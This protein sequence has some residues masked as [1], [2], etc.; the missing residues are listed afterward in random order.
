MN[1]IRSALAAAMRSQAAPTIE[2]TQPA[3]PAD[4]PIEV[5][6][7]QPEQSIQRSGRRGTERRQSGPH[8]SAAITIRALG[9]GS[10][11]TGQRKSEPVNREVPRNWNR[12]D[13]EAF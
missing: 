8:N 9:G 5:N 13:R 1:D 4:E 12:A 7:G 11:E 6:A 3:G 10:D 2:D